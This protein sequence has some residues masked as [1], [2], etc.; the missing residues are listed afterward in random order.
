MNLIFNILLFPIKLLGNAVKDWIYK[1][2]VKVVASITILII[3]T[4]IFSWKI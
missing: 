3:I 2:I 1:W 4:Y